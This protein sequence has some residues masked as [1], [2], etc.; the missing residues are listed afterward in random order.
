[1]TFPMVFP[2]L[3]VPFTFGKGTFA[4][5]LSK[6]ILFFFGVLLAYSYL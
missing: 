5:K 6:K 1:M 4:Q 3:F 2:C